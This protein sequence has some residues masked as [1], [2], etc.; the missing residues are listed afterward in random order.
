MSI[1][2][3]ID[4]RCPSQ[5]ARIGCPAKTRTCPYVLNASRQILRGNETIRKNMWKIEE[6]EQR[7]PAPI[8]LPPL[9]TAT[10]AKLDPHEVGVNS[11]NW[12]TELRASVLRPAHRDSSHGGDGAYVFACQWLRR[13]PPAMDL[14]TQ[15]GRACGLRGKR[16][17]GR[18][19]ISRSHSR[20]HLYPCET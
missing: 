4:G 5:F 13:P 11:A 3:C 19:R 6:K 16:L 10:L 9:D 7:M 18:G 17:W 12:T 1:A 20:L 2:R 14:T 15:S 8:T